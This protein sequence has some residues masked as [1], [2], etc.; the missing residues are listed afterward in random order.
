[1]KDYYFFSY[2]LVSGMHV[3]GEDFENKVLNYLVDEFKQ[4]FHLRVF[5]HMRTPAE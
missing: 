2:R 1:M 4:K 5:Y 3:E